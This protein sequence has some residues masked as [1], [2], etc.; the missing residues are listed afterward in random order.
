MDRKNRLWQYYVRY[1][2]VLAEYRKKK[3]KHRPAGSRTTG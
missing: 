3:E 2:K 1:Q